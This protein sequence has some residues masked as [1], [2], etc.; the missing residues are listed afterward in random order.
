MELNRTVV[1]VTCYSVYYCL[2]WVLNW[3][4]AEKWKLLCSLISLR[5]KI[6][7]A[8]LG[9]KC[10]EHSEPILPHGCEEAL[11]HVVCGQNYLWVAVHS[12]Y[13]VGCQLTKRYVLFRLGCC[14]QLRRILKTN[15]KY[16]FSFSSCGGCRRVSSASGLV[17]VLSIWC[18]S[19]GSQGPCMFR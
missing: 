12:A 3:Y 14:F 7:S 19:R 2:I 1:S 18:S 17:C 15:S 6:S 8:S 4:T 10:S 5:W 11:H 16:L 13:A 9:K